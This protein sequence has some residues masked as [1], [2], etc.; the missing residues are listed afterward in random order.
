MNL[1]S[2]EQISELSISKEHDEEHD[3]ESEDVFGTS[4]QRGGQL[5]HGLTETDV[6][7]NLQG[8]EEST[9]SLERQQSKIAQAICWTERCQFFTLIHAKN[10]LTAF[11][12]LYW[13]CQNARNSKS[14]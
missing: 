10:R 1:H 7:K 9:H 8:Q 2:K 13:V 14:E 12:L 3:G 11:M 6:L 4:A 5:I